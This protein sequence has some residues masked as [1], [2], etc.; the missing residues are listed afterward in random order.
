MVDSHLDVRHVLKHEQRAATAR[1]DNILSR[2]RACGA[3]AALLKPLARPPD[4]IDAANAQDGQRFAE[5]TPSIICRGEQSEHELGTLTESETLDLDDETG[6]K[7]PIDPGLLADLMETHPDDEQSFLVDD[8][9]AAGLESEPG[10]G[11]A[12][13]EADAEYGWLTDS[14]PS[15]LDDY[16][17]DLSLGSEDSAV[18][19]D[20]GV[21]SI[22]ELL[23]DDGLP[24]NGEE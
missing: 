3:R 2:R 17:S 12:A 18:L 8:R 19:D 11:G 1:L 21:L 24:L 6:A 14:S 10:E 13:D 9:E 7:D 15:G 4:R 20:G 23:G 22:E 16:V 5:L